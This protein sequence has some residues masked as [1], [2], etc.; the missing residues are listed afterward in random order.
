MTD[1]LK[2]PEQEAYETIKIIKDEIKTLT[3]KIKAEWE[4]YEPLL[5]HIAKRDQK[6]QNNL[7]GE[8]FLNYMEIWE[9]Q[10][11]AIQKEFESSNK[12]SE[13][14]DRLSNYKQKKEMNEEILLSIYLERYKNWEDFLLFDL[15]KDDFMKRKLM[16][17]KYTVKNVGKYDDESKYI[18]DA[19]YSEYE[20]KY[21]KKLED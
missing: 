2:M 14:F 17:I 19:E 11:K 1:N 7:T 13:L 21:R 8:E 9:E 18:S 3:N 20:S 15:D 5:S 10:K 6:L 16:K 12:Y 4:H